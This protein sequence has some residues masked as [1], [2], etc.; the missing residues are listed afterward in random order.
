MLILGLG[1]LLISRMMELPEFLQPF[2][3]VLE[4][5]SHLVIIPLLLLPLAMTMALL[6]KTKEVLM[7]SVFGSKPR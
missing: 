7:D 6:W 5:G 2:A 1:Y 4:T 3:Q